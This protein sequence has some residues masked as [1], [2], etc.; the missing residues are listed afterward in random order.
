MVSNPNDLLIVAGAGQYPLLVAQGARAAG[1]KRIAVLALRGQTSRKMADYADQYRCISVGEV[2]RSLDWIASQGI[3]DV[4]LAG[5]IKPTALFTTRFDALAREIVGS[6][7]IKSA[8]TIFAA[9]IGQL[10]ERGIRV[11]P[12]STYMGRHLPEPGVLSARDPDAREKAD[13]ERGIQ[14]ALAVGTVDIG[15]TV[16]VREG[17]VLA[18][19]AFEGTNAAIRRGGRLGGPGAV[20]VKLARAEHD[21]RFDIP[22]VGAGTLRPLIN[23]KI[24]TLAIQARRTL[25]LDREKVIA[26]VN[27]RGIAL[28]AFASDM[29]AAPTRPPARQEC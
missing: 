22:V 5:Q 14:A 24:S 10:A 27:R 13:I 12:A 9:A 28:V 11:L 1:V 4:M 29:P 21:M 19:E 6:L 3:H 15:Q 17:M 7:K 16:V 8:H 23:M 18:V 25:L 2:R 26:T 20:V